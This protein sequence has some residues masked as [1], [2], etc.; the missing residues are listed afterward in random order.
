MNQDSTD[1]VYRPIAQ[2]GGAGFLLIRTMAEPEA[3][4]SQ[5]RN[6]IYEL[7]TDTAIDRIQTL[8]DARDESISSPRLT[9][10]L[11]S[12]FAALALVIT[13][14]GIAGMMA[15]SVTQRRHELGIRLALGATRSNVLWL[16][17]R[18]GMAL[19]F[20]GLTLGVIGALTL[21]RWLSTLLFAVEPTDPLT[22]IS[23][24]VVLATVA[25]IAC[26]VPARRVTGIDPMI[27]L[28][29]E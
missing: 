10:V 9:A 26:F 2:A 11:L 13:A 6:A 8:E 7:D 19:V 25:A 21:T 27:A 23:V 17:L 1:E 22:F 18:Q 16:V 14:A 3:I 5:T 15:L 28:R 12:L 4:I 24:S 20:I 29:S